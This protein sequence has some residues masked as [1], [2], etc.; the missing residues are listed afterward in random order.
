MGGLKQRTPDPRISR[1]SYLMHNLHSTPDVVTLF[2][3]WRGVIDAGHVTDVIP[4]VINV[5]P[6]RRAKQGE[7]VKL[8]MLQD[9]THLPR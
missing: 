6:I 3:E 7:L 1:G 5:D 2:R 8:V 4:D 9:S